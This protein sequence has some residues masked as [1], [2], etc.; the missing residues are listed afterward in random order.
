MLKICCDPCNTYCK[1][2]CNSK[3]REDSSIQIYFQWKQAYSYIDW[4]AEAKYRSQ[5]QK[6]TIGFLTVQNASGLGKLSVPFSIRPLCAS[7]V[8][9]HFKAECQQLQCERSP[10]TREFRGMSCTHGANCYFLK[11]HQVGPLPLF[12]GKTK[13]AFPNATG[14]NL[15]LTAQLFNALWNT[16]KTCS[17]LQC[18]SASRKFHAEWHT[19]AEKGRRKKGREREKM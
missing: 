13:T 18:C 16:R 19:G 7:S 10:Q 9:H 5:E 4:A 1:D 12:P 11:K 15:V 3:S 6:E 2:C 8:F 17:G 14:E